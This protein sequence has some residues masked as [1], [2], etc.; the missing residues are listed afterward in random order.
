AHPGSAVGGRDGPPRPASP[1]PPLGTRSR[2]RRRVHAPTGLSEPALNG[3]QPTRAD[4]ESRSAPQPTLREKPDLQTHRC[5]FPA[6]GA[7]THPPRGLPNPTS[8]NYPP[9]GVLNT[10]VHTH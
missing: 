4:G 5:P 8:G 1:G 2:T 7:P 9:V 3:G 10:S 6:P